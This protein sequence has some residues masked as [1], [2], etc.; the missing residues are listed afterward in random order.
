MAFYGVGN[1][2][3][4]PTIALIDQISGLNDP[5]LIHSDTD[6]YFASVDKAGLKTVRDE[7]Q[8]HARGCYSPYT[9]IKAVTVDA[10]TTY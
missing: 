6:T 4:G 10:K 2:G 5:E 3:G 9:F 7:L 1:H 8:H